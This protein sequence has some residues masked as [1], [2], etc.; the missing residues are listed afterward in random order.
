VEAQPPNANNNPSNSPGQSL[1]WA[2]STVTIEGS[3]QVH[4]FI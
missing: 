1:L 3:L 2:L 4:V